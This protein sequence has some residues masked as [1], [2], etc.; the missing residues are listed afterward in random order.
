M[1]CSLKP[2]TVLFF[3]HSSFFAAVLRLRLH[4]I[5]DRGGMNHGEKRGRGGSGQGEPKEERCGDGGEEECDGVEGNGV[6]VLI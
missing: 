3:H 5:Q 4:W 6:E 2:L 1:L